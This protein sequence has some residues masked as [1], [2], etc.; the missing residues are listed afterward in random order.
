MANKPHLSWDDE[1]P[2]MP[3]LSV[4]CDDDPIR[5]GLID[6]DGNDL[7]AHREPAGFCI[8][9]RPR[10]RVKAGRKVIA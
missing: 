5:S 7:V 1:G 10:Y 2:V 3:H 6:V 9:P 4:Y 8:V